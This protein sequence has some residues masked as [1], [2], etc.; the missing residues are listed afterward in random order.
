MADTILILSQTFHVKG[1]SKKL[2]KLKKA[3]NFLSCYHLFFAIWLALGALT[4]L[5][6]ELE[7]L[8]AK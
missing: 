6:L 8:M 7:Y 2:Q 3:G 5:R 1:I 4:S